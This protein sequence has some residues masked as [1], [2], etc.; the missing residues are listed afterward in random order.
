MFFRQPMLIVYLMAI[1]PFFIGC[2]GLPF[3]F[4]KAANQGIRKIALLNI[5]E[6]EITVTGPFQIGLVFALGQAGE[7]AENAKEFNLSVKDVPSIGKQLEKALEV[8]LNKS[9]YEVVTI[10]GAR[11]KKNELVKDYGGISVNADAILDLQ[12][13]KVGYECDQSVYRYQRFE[14]VLKIRARMVSVKTRDVIYW[15]LFSWGHPPPMSGPWRII[16]PEMTISYL[17]FEKLRENAQDA[18]GKLQLGVN[19]IASQ[20]ANDLKRLDQ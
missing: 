17:T 5:D 19:P 13:W 16:P 7:D 9:G 12:I 14:P 11:K 15:Q 3:K 4:D 2:S 10:Q 8:E 18:A 6:P 1:F 20:I